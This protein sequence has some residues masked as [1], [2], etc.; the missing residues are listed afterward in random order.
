MRGADQPGGSVGWTA[1]FE[2]KETLEFYVGQI[3]GLEPQR[4]GRLE[5]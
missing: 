2:A 4:R 5:G 1:A 3:A